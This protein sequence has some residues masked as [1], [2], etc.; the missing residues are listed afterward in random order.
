MKKKKNHFMN[1]KQANLFGVNFGSVKETH[2]T[3]FIKQLYLYKKW[4]DCF[5]WQLFHT[6]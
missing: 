6:E 4:F 3:K 2:I 5:T 1:K